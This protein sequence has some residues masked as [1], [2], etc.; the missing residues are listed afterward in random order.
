MSHVKKNL[1]YSFTLKKKINEDHCVLYTA[2]QLN[3]KCTPNC[4]WCTINSLK[5][6][7]TWKSMSINSTVFSMLGLNSLAE[8]LFLIHEIFI[9]T[10]QVWEKKKECVLLL[11]WQVV[12]A[13]MFHHVMSSFLLGNNCLS[14]DAGRTFHFLFLLFW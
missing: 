12:S 9:K 3:S 6:L 7:F 10:L 5:W 14:T 2:L 11:L 13:S 1:N 8:F 4:K